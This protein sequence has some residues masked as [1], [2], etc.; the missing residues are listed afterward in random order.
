ME[1]EDEK[2]IKLKE[3]KNY[4][5][6][7]RQLYCSLDEKDLLDSTG[8]LLKTEIAADQKP[9]DFDNPKNHQNT[10]KNVMIWAEAKEQ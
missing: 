7:L 8:N 6:C 10:V 5:G 1:K 9:V 2:D 3:G 4:Y